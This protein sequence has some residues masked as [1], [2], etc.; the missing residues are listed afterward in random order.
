MMPPVVT[1][2]QVPDA[3][4]ALAEVAAMAVAGDAEAAVATWGHGCF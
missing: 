1:C 2:F 4:T 3:A